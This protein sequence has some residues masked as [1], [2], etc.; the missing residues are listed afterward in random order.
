MR[1]LLAASLGLAL[2]SATARPVSAQECATDADC[3]EGTC[4]DAICRVAVGERVEVPPELGDRYVLET[5]S[6]W[7][8]LV[9]GG[10]LF[11]AAWIGTIAAVGATAEDD[12]RGA[13][14]GQAFV[15]AAGP[16][17]LH[18]SGKVPEDVSGLVIITGA[19]QGLG[20]LTAFVGLTTESKVLTPTGAAAA[21]L[22]ITPLVGRGAAGERVT[23]LGVGGRF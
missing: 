21:S 2:V 6:Y 18:S 10:S 20:L 9:A 1:Q 4:V 12:D 8:L 14:I 17:I 19:L 5:R 22:V 15:P 16:V 13:A 23:G 3:T 11:A 7:P